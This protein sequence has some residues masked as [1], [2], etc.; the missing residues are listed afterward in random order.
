MT[1]NKLESEHELNDLYEDISLH[2]LVSQHMQSLDIDPDNNMGDDLLREMLAKNM[3]ADLQDFEVEKEKILA[4][5]TEAY[6]LGCD[7]YN[8]GNLELAEQELIKV[9]RKTESRPHTKSLYVRTEDFK[10]GVLDSMYQLGLVYL[11]NDNFN[12]H[13]K[14]AA[15]FQYCAKFSEVHKIGDYKEF[16]NKAYLTEKFFLESLGIMDGNAVEEDAYCNNYHNKITNYKNELEIHRAE[17]K[18]Q[19]GSIAGLTVE[20]IAERSI[21]IVKLYKNSTNFFVDYDI[22]QGLAQRLISEC[23]EQLGNLPTGCEYA[24]IGLGSLAGAKMTPWSDLEFAVLIN[25]NK[26][27][28]RE[29][30]LRLTKLLSIKVV[31]FGE[32]MLRGMGIEALNNFSTGKSNDDWFWDSTIMHSGFSFDGTHPHACKLPFGR[33]GYNG[34]EDFSLI[35]TPEQMAEFQKGGVKEEIHNWFES[36]KHLVQGLRNVSLITG[37]QNLLDRYRSEI[38]NSAESSSEEYRQTLKNRALEILREDTEKFSLQLGEE[39]DGKLLDTKRDIYRLGDRVIDALANYYDILPENGEPMLSAWEVIDKMV[40]RHILSLEGAQHLKEAL[41]IATELRLNTYCHN[42]GQQSESIRTYEPS[43]NH[44]DEE[45]RI[46]LIEKTFYIKDTSILHYF[47]YVMLGVQ[48]L[49]KKFFQ[50]ESSEP[51]EVLI[52]FDNFFDCGNYNKSMVHARFLEYDKAQAYMKA[53]EEENMR[54]MELSR[55]L[56]VL[57]NRTGAIKEAELIAKRILDQFKLEHPEQYEKIAVSYNNL[58][59]IYRLAGEFKKAIEC[60]IEALKLRLENNY[61]SE[62][63]HSQIAGSY[64]NIGD[65]Y[66]YVREYEK[67]LEYHNK[68]LNVEIK[69]YQNNLF[70]SDIGGSFNNLGVVYY[71]MKE[72]N[73]AA[74][75]LEGGLVVK[76][77]VYESTPNHPSVAISYDNLGELYN[78]LGNNQKALDYCNI[79]LAMRLIAY[80][81][82]SNHLEIGTS[83][84]NLGEIWAARGNYSKAIEYYHHALKV[85]FIAYENNHNHPEIAKI[86]G[87]LGVAYDKLAQYEDAINCSKEA[88]NIYSAVYQDMPDHPDIIEARN[89]LNASY[90]NADIFL[91][92]QTSIELVGQKNNF[93]LAE[94]QDV[95]M[96]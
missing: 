79:A 36:D 19:L 45:Q 2:E 75:Y 53:A 7:Y 71:Y 29:Y 46:K 41:S 43:V 88:L 26:E 8:D 85:K 24:I 32:T 84:V 33:Q 15:I 28:Y 48:D 59:E 83:Y 81:N 13:A 40:E 61:N 96:L 21:E 9:L 68:A 73:R 10:Q 89:N 5:M 11:R 66:L 17:I 42:N 78:F 22:G 49:I 92:Q 64:N 95:D 12:H 56:L 72:Y 94:Q 1:K 51:L 54:N 34:H 67:A 57:Y 80:G 82:D 65:A 70:H 47:Y 16:L 31:N 50:Q 74:E 14:A 18:Q 62:F 3:H 23:L 86:Y 44:L 4:E 39:V 63:S 60:H 52:S 20:N 91:D 58:G 69:I 77:K 90:L 38:S 27:E 25:N 37:S 76:L 30:F 35:S 87:N 55:E 93:D 6:G